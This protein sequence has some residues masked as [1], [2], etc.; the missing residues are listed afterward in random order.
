M[1]FEEASSSSNLHQ[2]TCRLTYSFVQA[3]LS[4]LGLTLYGFHSDP[5]GAV[6]A[7][8]RCCL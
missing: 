3:K 5:A 8:N 4:F 1:L 2:L 6:D 7:D